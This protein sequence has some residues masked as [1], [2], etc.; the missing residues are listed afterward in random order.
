MQN[1]S[2]ES[3]ICYAVNKE[4][5]NRKYKTAVLKSREPPSFCI[6]LKSQGAE[7]PYSI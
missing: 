4:K 5:A 2:N 3:N 7:N 6:K 1:V